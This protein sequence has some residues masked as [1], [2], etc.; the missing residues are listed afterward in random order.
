MNSTTSTT[1]S[2]TTT[3]KALS[4]SINVG[5]GGLNKKRPR[6]SDDN[7]QLHKAGFDTS[8]QVSSTSS[9]HHQ[10][11]TE[12]I[13]SAAGIF[14]STIPEPEK[15]KLIIPLSIPSILSTDNTTTST[16]SSSVITNLPNTI[17]SLISST[18]TPP[19]INNN[20]DIQNLQNKLF[21]NISSSSTSTSSVSTTNTTKVP[22]DSQ[23]ARLKKLREIMNNTMNNNNEDEIHHDL[24]LRP[25]EQDVHS[26]TYT[27]IPIAEFGAAML[28]GMGVSEQELKIAMETPIINNS[29]QTNN[30]LPSG[31]REKIG[32]IGAA[33]NP[34]TVLKSTAMM[35]TM[36]QLS[37]TPTNTSTTVSKASLLR[38]QSVMYGRL[39][40]KQFAKN[41]ITQ[42]IVYVWQLTGVPGLSKIRIRN[43]VLNTNNTEL[44]TKIQNIS[45]IMEESIYHE[46]LQHIKTLLPFTIVSIKDI[47]PIENI[48]NLSTTEQ[49]IRETIDMLLK[50]EELIE[51][52]IKAKKDSNKLNSNLPNS[53][54][55][56]SSS[57]SSSSM[58]SNTVPDANVNVP[59]VIQSS[60]TITISDSAT[61]TS[62]SSLSGTN[63][64]TSITLS[65]S[66]ELNK[67]AVIVSWLIP[68]IIVRIIDEHFLHG[69]YFRQKAVVQDVPSPYNANILVLNNENTYLDNVP[70]KYL[71]TALPKI[72]GKIMVVRGN[73]R[74]NVGEVIERNSQTQKITVRFYSDS[75]IKVLNY[76]DVAEYA[77]TIH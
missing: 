71:E 75:K 14:T 22:Q 57:S 35:P 17:P 18:T 27:N 21:R 77:G 66:N 53:S 44:L 30:V 13:I 74:N 58:E 49:T 72:G 6:P 1:S 15:P 9:N 23:I 5:L 54:S 3:N 50:K 59:T 31:K 19:S 37:N 24:S 34:L 52:W 73:Y 11:S 46:Y 25:Q 41:T 43:Y 29:S 32:G 56:A 65:S 4:V 2:S 62:I 51:K 28:R 61:I 42:E 36:N 68:G 69:K 76:D 20:S 70:E 47:E 48:N 10:Q 45:E 16:F 7:E 60:S 40:E 26:T 64:N 38:Q 67:P 33:S 12:K 39:Q 55:A 8:S 63:N